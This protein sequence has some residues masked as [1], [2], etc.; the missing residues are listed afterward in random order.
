MDSD[1]SDTS[2]RRRRCRRGRCLWTR[3]ALARPRRPAAREPRSRSSRAARTAPQVIFADATVV[4][5]GV[6][7]E[8][9][10]RVERVAL[11]RAH[12][13]R[14]DRPCPLGH[15]LASPRARSARAAVKPNKPQKLQLC[16]FREASCR[17][18][19]RRRVG[20]SLSYIQVINLPLAERARVHTQCCEK[21]AP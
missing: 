1:D 5:R 10:A 3:R 12:G 8:R 18:I 14:A 6:G 4:G 15:N 9:A 11:L 20:G 19:R 17:E 13:L 21:P 7:A 16:N 2:S